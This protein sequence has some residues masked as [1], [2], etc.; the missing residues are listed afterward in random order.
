MRFCTV[1]SARMH[2]PRAPPPPGQ[3]LPGPRAPVWRRHS[4]TCSL[5]PRRVPTP[6]EIR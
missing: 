2:G 5:A 1:S 6:R 3:Q 4:Q